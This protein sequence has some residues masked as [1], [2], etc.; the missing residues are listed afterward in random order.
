MSNV[1]KKNSKVSFM[2]KKL[3][4]FIYKLLDDINKKEI[5]VYSAQSSFYVIISAFPFIMLLISLTGFLLPYYKETLDYLIMTFT[6]QS[7]SPEITALISEL[8]EKSLPAISFASVASLWSASRGI[9]SI[10]RGIYKIY[11]IKPY[12]N[13]FISVISSIGYTIAFI[14]IL[15]FTLI[16]QVFGGVIIT[17]LLENIPFSY[18]EII[19]IKWIFYIFL[20][21]A[22]FILLYYFL[23]KR[24][25]SPTKH[26]P[27]AL[28][29]ALGWGLFSKIY[30]I[31]IENFSDY[32]YIYGSLTAVVLMMLWIYFCITI[33]LLGAQLNNILIKI[34]KKE[35]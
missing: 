16:I 5:T 31:Y 1:C 4:E 18:T 28:F 35:W 34:K 17:G 29:S 26:F 14:V 32:S 2:I 9:A 22:T 6:P 10:E 8:Y 7:I 12:K 19:F 30:S 20:L 23:S 27:G 33:F 25:Y 13:F 24:K 15:I 21:T 3:T 11:D